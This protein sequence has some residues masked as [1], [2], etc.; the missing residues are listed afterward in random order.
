[1]FNI[2]TACECYSAIKAEFHY[3]AKLNQI[4][5]TLK[6]CQLEAVMWSC[7]HGYMRGHAVRPALNHC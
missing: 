1:M 7:L 5:P 2:C 3:L 4:Q 6:K